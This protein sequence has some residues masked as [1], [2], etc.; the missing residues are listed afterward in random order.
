MNMKIRIENNFELST[1]QNLTVTS[2]QFKCD[3]W[4]AEG[5][6]CFSKFV[7]TFSI[8]ATESKEL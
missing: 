2:S 3:I 1:V 4:P 7:L 6:V 8:A 5:Y